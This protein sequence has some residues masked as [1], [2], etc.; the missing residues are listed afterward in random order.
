MMTVFP[1]KI[2]F[3]YA[4]L[5]YKSP[6]SAEEN[7]SKLK[8]MYEQKRQEGDFIYGY[9]TK[10][11]NFTFIYGG[12]FDLLIKG[13]LTSA[14]TGSTIKVRARI[15]DER[16]VYSNFYLIFICLLIFTLIVGS[17]VVMYSLGIP[18]PRRFGPRTGYE[19]IHFIWLC[20]IILITM[21]GVFSLA[22]I[23][24]VLM[25]KSFNRQCRTVKLVLQ[26]IFNTEA[27]IKEVKK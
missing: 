8:V 11:N 17:Y 12:A 10:D 1:F 16:K 20:G 14:K 9:E 15:K 13:K 2:A 5:S 19:F 4:E 7:K 6:N 23:G 3:P 25:H 22:T 27:I 24:A 26:E 18:L 21:I